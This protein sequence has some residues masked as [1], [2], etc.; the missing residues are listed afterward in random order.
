MTVYRK[1]HEEVMT[2]HNEVDINALA[3]LI[4]KKVLDN[5]QDNLQVNYTQPTVRSG[6]FQVEKEE[7]DISSSMNDLAKNMVV[8]RG[9]SSS[10][11]N[12]LGGVKETKKEN[13][14][15]N[16][17]IDFLSDLED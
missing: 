10:N 9:N 4:S 1:R 8:Q 16:N 6:S 12:D 3:D 13:D 15:T 11:F 7:F 17:T 14:Q 5:L 2:R